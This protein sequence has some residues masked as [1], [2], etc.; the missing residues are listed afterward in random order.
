[1]VLYFAFISAESTPRKSDGCAINCKSLGIIFLLQNQ[2]I[3]YLVS[4]SV[5]SQLDITYHD[6]DV[7]S[8]DRTLNNKEKPAAKEMKRAEKHSSYLLQPLCSEDS[9]GK[10]V[11]LKY[12]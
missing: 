2:K 10:V 6:L 11:L 12:L 9:A 3:L 5:R 7:N 4:D 8:F 1:M